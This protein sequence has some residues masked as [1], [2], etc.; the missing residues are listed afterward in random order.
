ML[1]GEATAAPDD[2]D[3]GMTASSGVCMRDHPHERRIGPIAF[4]VAVALA[5]PAAG[6]AHAQ[7]L[8]DDP[9]AASD[10]QPTEEAITFPSDR[11]GSLQAGVCGL[12]DGGTLHLLP[13]TYP[14]PLVVWGKDVRIAGEGTATDWPTIQMAEPETVAAPGTGVGVITV[15]G[16]ADLEL[17]KAHIVGGDA[18]ILGLPTAG[19]IEVKHVALTNNGR[20]ILYRSDADLVVKHFVIEDTLW[21]GISLAPVNLQAENCGEMKVKHGFFGSQ[22]GAGIYIRGCIAGEGV[23]QLHG[24]EIQDVTLLDP[25]GG[26]IVAIGTIVEIDDVFIPA[27]RYWGALLVNTF[28]EVRRSTILGIDKGP[29]FD[30]GTGQYSD[31]FGDGI[32]IFSTNDPSALGA[33]PPPSRVTVDDNYI[34]NLDRVALALFG[35]TAALK[36]NLIWTAGTH[37]QGENNEGY[38]YVFENLGGNVCGDP[39]DGPCIVESIGL[40]PPPL[41]QVGE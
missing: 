29:I 21:N 41:S 34:L 32:T 23:L 20:G 3:S 17:D 6:A 28:A 30:P 14:G 35:G 4:L 22:G 38:P 5:I 12:I 16:D 31:R 36:N 15:G 39:P 25:Q 7:G 8:P 19:S 27:A 2:G 37:L 40:E 18:G 33:F 1:G 9:C 11:Y 10:I 26:G 24:H 13:G